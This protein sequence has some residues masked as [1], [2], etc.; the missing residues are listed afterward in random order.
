M[1]Y[2]F[3]R[4]RSQDLMHLVSTP[5]CIAMLS[6]WLAFQSVFFVSTLVT[7]ADSSSMSTTSQAL[8]NSSETVEFLPSLI[9][10][11]NSSTLSSDRVIDWS[12]GSISPGTYGRSC[13]DAVRQMAFV[14]GSATKQFTWGKRDH[15]MSAYNVNLP[16]RVYSCMRPQPVA[17]SIH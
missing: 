2:I 16:Q 13:F 9:N 5:P 8:S 12:C 7:P 4:Q 10:T 3:K 15:S 14:P 17:S 6:F 1:I 11:T